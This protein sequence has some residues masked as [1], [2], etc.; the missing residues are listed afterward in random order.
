MKKKASITYG[1][2][3]VL[4]L[5]AGLVVPSGLGNSATVSADPGIMRW[6]T[7]S[8]PGSYPG[9][10]INDILTGSEINTLAVGPNGSTMLASVTTA[11]SSISYY[12]TWDN[13]RSWGSGSPY[14]HIVFDAAIAPDNASF[15]AVVTSAS[16][17]APMEVWVSFDG[18]TTWN[19]TGLATVLAAGE[20]VRAID[21]SP[22]YGG[23]R[24]IAVA[25]VTGAG[26]GDIFVIKSTGFNTWSAQNI[27]TK[28][29]IAADYYAI[30]FSPTYSGDSSLA[31]V[32]AT[33]SGTFYNI[34][35]RDIDQNTTLNFAFTNAVGG[36]E[37]KDPAWTTG[38]SPNITTLNVARLQLPSD[39]SG[40]AVSLRR[41]YISTDCYA[42][43]T[44]KNG[45]KDGIFRIDD[46]TVYT[47]MDTSQDFTKSIYSIAYFGTYASGKLLAGERMGY[48]CTATVPTWFTDSPTTCPVPCWYPCLKCPTGAA[49]GLC[50]TGGKTGVGG[51]LVGWG[52]AGQLN[53]TL[54]YV[55]TGSEAATV[56]A[57]FTPATWY[58]PWL[59]APIPNDETAFSISRN[60]GE[61]W[62][63]LGLIDTTIDWLNDVA[64]SPD[65]STVYLASVNR[66]HTGECPGQGCF[67]FDSVW[68]S[69]TNTAVTSPLPA[70]PIGTYW[71]RVFCHTTSLD[72]A[73]LQTDMPILRLPPYC[74]DL[75][76]GQLIAW[77]ARGTKAM[78]WSPDYGDYWSM[79]TPRDTVQ[80]F[81]FESSKIMY[82]LAS[83]QVDQTYTDVCTDDG[84]ADMDAAW[85]CPNIEGIGL[86]Q[87][88]PFTGTAWSTLLP[89]VDSGLAGTHT[90]AAMPEG[91]VLVGA[92]SA[93]NIAMAAAF[94]PNFNTDSPAFTSLW[95]IQAGSLS[96]HGD[97]HV[98]F[99][100]DF[101][102][103]GIVYTADEN[104]MSTEESCQSLDCDGDW[105]QPPCST[106]SVYR[107]TYPSAKRWVEQDMMDPSNGACVPLASNGSEMFTGGFYGIVNAFT[108]ASTGSQGEPS[109]QTALYAAQGPQCVPAESTCPNGTTCCDLPE[110]SIV[111]RTLWPQDGMPKPGIVWD[112]LQTYTPAQ[113]EGVWFTLEPSS[114]KECGSCS[115]DTNTTLYAIDNE[116]CGEFMGPSGHLANPNPAACP[117]TGYDPVNTQ[118]GMLWTYTDCLA[119]K[120][121]ALVTEDK[122]LIGCDPV[123]GR[124]EEVNLCWEQLCVATGYEVQ[125][126]K[127]DDFSISV[128]DWVNKCDFDRNDFFAPE[129][130]SIPCAYIPAGGTLN[131]GADASEAAVTLNGFME[132]GHT[133]YWR[134]QVRSSATGEVA[135]SPWS[136]TR[137]FTIKAGLPVT[138]PYSGLQLLSPSN[139]ARGIP[140]T[141][142]SF[143][144]SPMG[145][146]TSYKFQLAKDAA[147]T[148]IV[149]E[150]TVS[151]TAYEVTD[152]LDHSTNYFWRVQPLEPVPGDWSA[153]FSFT[154][155][156]PPPLPA[157]PVEAP[158]TPTWI[159]VIVAVAVILVLLIVILTFMTR[160]TP[161]YP[162]DKK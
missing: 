26:G 148:Q 16:V 22:D 147:M 59:L 27:N 77:A 161:T 145:D 138:T 58:A 111:F 46:S 56:T 1:L 132:C 41:A 35:Y 94:C 152:Q 112:A 67:Q 91:Q 86:V 106:G 126:A 89:S 47:L 101:K 118:Q 63:Q 34:A 110:N 107:N 93:N 123:S 19:L 105:P 159:W 109:N 142:V 78:A 33:D 44:T 122:S 42:D 51:A 9:A 40:T 90:I 97:V 150:A 20:T 87:K 10:K 129:R 48:Q 137:S 85:T 5:V 3:A 108:G 45:K 100:Q 30:K 65:C 80:D 6:T 156:A 99:D 154:T 162:L 76:D 50:A 82:V 79:I 119:K 81:C 125:I 12:S 135:R 128:I 55:A 115:V 64:P 146:T 43:G 103:N 71:E 39:F 66:F 28:L 57:P 62:N 49:N 88:L 14:G 158:A 124:A 75:P 8:T 136:E 92:N 69:S 127:T 130:T 139:G 13:G 25:T 61:T 143:S 68:R 17:N 95:M 4:M 11:V 141:P 113:I 131:K 38:T 84:T 53:G 31:F 83:D 121:P 116:A 70:L 21:I 149:K 2:L 7:V 29:G 104:T 36:I 23:T 160:R 37:V 140:A 120:G 117:D 98:A 134:V 114:L 54:G 144:W 74:N 60:N 32:F 24:D 72:C 73:H 52:G 157:A 102:D 96:D 18:G 151:T 153:T 155:G 133:Y 15:W